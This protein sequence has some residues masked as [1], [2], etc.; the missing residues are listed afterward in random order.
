MEE[1][2]DTIGTRFRKLRE[3]KH[4]TQAQTADALGISLALYSRIEND[5]RMPSTHTL[6]AAADLYSV[7]IDYLLCRS[8]SAS[9]TGLSPEALQVLTADYSDVP[10][11]R[12]AVRNETHLAV[13]G[14][15]AAEEFQNLAAVLNFLLTKGRADRGSGGLLDLLRAYFTTADDSTIEGLE[16]GICSAGRRG[17][18]LDSGQVAAGMYYARI[19]QLLVQYRDECQRIGRKKRKSQ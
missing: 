6:I 3:A 9:A 2:K 4:L 18:H 8:D 5:R 14:Y 12:L 7:S 15:S 1:K 16:D 10:K 17:F 11:N 13:Q 19:Q